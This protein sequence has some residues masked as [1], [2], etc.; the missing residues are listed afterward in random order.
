[1]CTEKCVYPVPE[2]SF[3]STSGGGARTRLA[4][5]IN[6]HTVG[7][8]LNR[9]SIDRVTPLQGAFGH[10]GH[11]LHQTL[12]VQRHAMIAARQRVAAGA[13]DGKPR[14]AMRA[15]ILQAAQRAV[16]AAPDH[17]IATQRAG[18]ERLKRLHVRRFRHD[19]PVAQ[20]P[21]VDPVFDM[22]VQSLV[23]HRPPRKER[24]V[25]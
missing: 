24:V 5:E 21:F 15:I 13:P 19:V 2:I 14:A 11:A 10:A 16:L 22:L 12:A 6:E 7:R 9:E 17:E 20:E 8:F 4:G 3:G 18:R 1:M 23:H 25:P